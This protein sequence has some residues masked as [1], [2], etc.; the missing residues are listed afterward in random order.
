MTHDP[1]MTHDTCMIHVS[2]L[3]MWEGARQLE[4]IVV[5][6]Q[7]VLQLWHHSQAYETKK[8]VVM[9]AGEAAAAGVV[10]AV[11]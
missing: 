1:C 2:G 3:S 5:R 7:G 9:V 11:E 4:F 10:A 8:E 6:Y